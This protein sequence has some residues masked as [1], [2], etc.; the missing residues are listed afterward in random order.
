MLS[1]QRSVHVLLELKIETEKKIRSK[2]VSLEEFEES[3][4]SLYAV[5]VTLY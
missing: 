1:Q 5:K 4:T 3:F 2:E